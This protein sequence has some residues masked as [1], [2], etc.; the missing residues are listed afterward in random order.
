MRSP[1][2]RIQ[3]KRSSYREER[4]RK[5]WVAETGLADVI[6]EPWAV[7]RKDESF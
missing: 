3:V 6:R 1:G 4:F 5:V 2:A 7:V